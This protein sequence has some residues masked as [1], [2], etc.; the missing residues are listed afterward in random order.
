MR[1]LGLARIVTTELPAT[2]RAWRT[3]RITEWKATLLVRETA[4]LS[5]ED[6]LYVDALVCDDAERLEAMGERELVSTIQA[7]VCRLDPESV[8]SRRRRAEG[9]RHVS[10][11]AAPDTMTWLT[12]LLPVKEGVA[13]YA[14]LV[15]A[16]DSARAT[17]EPR[18][19]G[20][21]MADA[22]A[23]RVVQG[24]VDRPGARPVS[25]GLVMTDRD[26]FGSGA[27]P[28]HL[29]GIGPVPAELAREL[30]VG[31]LTGRERVWVRRLY[32]HP[33]TGELVAAD[34]RSRHFRGS[35]ARF[36]RLRDRVCRTPWCDAPV[37]HTDH[38]SEHAAEGPTSLV[39]G[40]G[41]CEACNYAKQAPGW[42]ARPSPDADGHEVETTM[43]T[44]HRYR[45]RPPPLVATVGR[46]PYRIDLVLAG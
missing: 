40:Q 12:A 26:L 28:A 30:L 45:S 13:A 18:S 27:E 38:P 20:Q 8:V 44:G 10:L 6:R 39:N 15:R 3:G 37:R 42:Q 21:V 24:A 11:R 43:P 19:K 41:L 34:A 31:A 32:C 35:L 46:T 4:C 1:D 2:W 9:D 5:R 36:I 17:G 29:D 33:R 14:A 22:L 7:E 23:A 25:L 16:A